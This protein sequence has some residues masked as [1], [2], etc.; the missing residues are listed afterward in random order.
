MALARMPNIDHHT[1]QIYTQSALA[2]RLAI[3]HHHR[4]PCQTRNTFHA[5]EQTR[6]SLDLTLHILRTAF[7]DQA[8]RA[9]ASD[10][11]SCAF[12]RISTCA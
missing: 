3:P 1:T 5:T 8:V 10:D 6:E 7:D 11:L 9:V 12:G 4:G 2:T